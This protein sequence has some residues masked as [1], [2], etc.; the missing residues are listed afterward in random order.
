MATD[1][2]HSES[3]RLQ[4][5]GVVA[6]YRESIA[7]SKVEFGDAA[8]TAMGELFVKVRQLENWLGQPA[9]V[10]T[11][12][13]AATHIDAWN[14]AR[15]AAHAEVREISERIDAARTVDDDVSGDGRVR[16]RLDIARKKLAQLVN[17]L[18]SVNFG[19]V[20]P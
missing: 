15:D 17:D 16:V 6:A 20:E 12:E 14:C 13:D 1:N 2:R 18:D 7:R 9:D 5:Q 11:E 4:A 10:D 8:I 3:I 19:R